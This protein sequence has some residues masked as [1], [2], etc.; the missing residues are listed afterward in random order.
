MWARQF[1]IHSQKN[2]A[3]QVRHSSEPS[4]EVILSSQ[5]E[6]FCCYW[7]VKM[8]KWLDDTTFL[9]L[10]HLGRNI[11]R[12]AVLCNQDTKRKVTVFW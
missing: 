8:F 12:V 9:S 10:S 7:P 6:H 3:V 5:S 4:F 1:C 11:I 2:L